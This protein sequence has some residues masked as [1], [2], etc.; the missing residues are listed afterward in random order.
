MSGLSDFLNPILPEEQEIYVSDRFVQH[1]EEGNVVMGRDGKPIP[2]LFR[3]R[4][5]TQAENDEI[6]K[7][8]TR[9]TVVKGQKVSQL[10]GLEY[11]RRLV[12]TATVD[13]DFSNSALCQHYGTLDPLEVPGKMLLSGEYNKLMEAI[14][15]LSGFGDPAE[16]EAKN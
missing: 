4:A 3:V 12:V 11:G 15:A 16:D 2:R 9:T 6:T 14:T 10:D 8:A 5:L 1:D 13:P 7:R